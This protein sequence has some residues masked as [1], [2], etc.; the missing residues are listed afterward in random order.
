MMSLIDPGSGSAVA[1]L[2]E[3]MEDDMLAAE[4]E[5]SSRSSGWDRRGEESVG[6]AVAFRFREWSSEGFLCLSR[7]S[8]DDGIWLGVSIIQVGSEILALRLEPQTT[9]WGWN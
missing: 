7:I 3:T 1:G 4:T 6:L 9:C 5:G 2:D 8:S